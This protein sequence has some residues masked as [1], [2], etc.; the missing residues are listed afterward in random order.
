MDARWYEPGLGGFLSRDSASL[1]FTGAE[2]LNRYG[3]GN[4][5]PVSTIDPTGHFAFLIPLAIVGVGLLA[6]LLAANA[7]Q[8]SSVGLGNSIDAIGSAYLDAGRKAYN[9]AQAAASWAW[10]QAGGIS[11]PGTTSGTS[12]GTSVQAGTGTSPTTSSPTQSTTTTVA[13]AAT[14]VIAP[15]PPPPPPYIVAE[16][17]TFRLAGAGSTV[18]ASVSGGY[19]V[20]TTRFW[21]DKYATD[22]A[23]WSDGSHAS[24]AEYYLGQIVVDSSAVR[25]RTVDPDRVIARVAGAIDYAAAGIGEYTNALFT[26]GACG[27]TA[28]ISACSGQG[29]KQV[30]GGNC[31]PLAFTQGACVTT[32]P[33][34]APPAASAKQPAPALATTARSRRLAAFSGRLQEASVSR[35]AVLHRGARV[36]DR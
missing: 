27:L 11:W 34:P 5:N 36:S 4:A 22:H 21:A 15:P 28:T 33:T 29:T 1:G 13:P 19:R 32:D 31:A 16:W 3:Y 30:V 17:T 12:S 2:S 8:S 26:G 18:S 6:G 7:S 24:S 9:G 23:A 10:N 25:I 35:L 20:V 14:R